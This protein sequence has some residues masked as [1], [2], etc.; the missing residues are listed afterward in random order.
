MTGHLLFALGA[1][2]A[3]EGLVMAL[4]PGRLDALLAALAGLSVEQRRI[5]G[6]AALTAGVVLI[7]LARGLGV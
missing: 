5:L 4:L 6:L 2:L 7:W 1:V 3:V